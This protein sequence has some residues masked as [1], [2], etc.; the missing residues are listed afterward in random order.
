MLAAGPF[1]LDRL[2][3]LPVPDLERASQCA[4]LSTYIIGVADVG[5]RNGWSRVLDL[6]S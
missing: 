6:A 3:R 2:S 5:E 1:G 4:R